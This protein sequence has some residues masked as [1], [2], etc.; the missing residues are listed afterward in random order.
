MTDDS[1]TRSLQESVLTLLAVDEVEGGIA[2][3][4]LTANVFDD[5]YQDIAGRILAYRKK[6]RKAPG[7]AHL[8]DLLDGILGNPKHKQHKTC[9]RILQGIT[10]QATGIN[11]TYIL[12][13]VNEFARKQTLKAAILT[14]GEAYQQQDE[15]VVQRVETILHKALKPDPNNMLDAGLFLND[16]ERALSFLEA[17]QSDY[18]LG[19]PQFD[20]VNLGPT[21]GEMLLFIAATGKGKSWW[22]VETARRCLLQGARVLHISLEMTE[23]QVTQRYFQNMFAI[24]KRQA[25]KLIA[26]ELLRDT[27]NR[28]KGLDL[29]NYTRPI[30]LDSED[31]RK[32]LVKNM[33]KWESLMARLVIK[34]FPAKSLTVQKLEGHL[35]LLESLG[36]I[37][38]VLVLDYPDLM[39]MDKDNPR[40]S[41]GWTFEELRGLLQKRSLAGVCPTQTNRLGWDATTVKAS[42][43][44]E[45]ASKLMTSDRAIIY[46]QSPSEAKRGLARLFVPKNRNDKDKFA[47]IITQNYATGQFVLDSAPMVSE[48]TYNEWIDGLQEA[49]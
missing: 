49:A 2:S 43:I 38:T 14:A 27:G 9:L 17:T 44:A 35:D 19:I 30:G 34:S 46:N 26:V 1:L 39:W 12:S 7:L 11:G 18:S 16:K 6:H 5:D 3:G 36:F 47:V 29:Y 8:D 25:E 10:D 24:P 20:R 42:M 33:N 13:R 37:P 15:D 31:I 32:H 41:L 45:D 22:T 21:R 23:R 28:L 4:L 48:S 40:I